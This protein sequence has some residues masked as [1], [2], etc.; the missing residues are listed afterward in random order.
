ML[1][2]FNVSAIFYTLL[3]GEQLQEKLYML[4]C[5]ARGFFH[6]FSIHDWFESTDAEPLIQ[7]ADIPSHSHSPYNL[8]SNG[9]AK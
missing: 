8:L 7:R 6:L 4:I 9:T 5:S 3:F 2:E 1:Y